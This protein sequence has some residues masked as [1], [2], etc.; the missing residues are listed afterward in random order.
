MRL[1]GGGALMSKHHMGG[2][3]GVRACVGEGRWVLLFYVGYSGPL[4]CEPS[5]EA[6]S[7]E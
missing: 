4:G 5:G 2:G 6:Y 1:G 7:R 3:L